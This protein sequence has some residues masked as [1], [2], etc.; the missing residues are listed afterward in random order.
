MIDDVTDA[1]EARGIPFAQIHREV[2]FH[3]AT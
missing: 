1:L 2:F 3:A